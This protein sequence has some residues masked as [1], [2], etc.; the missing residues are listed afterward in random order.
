MFDRIATRLSVVLAVVALGLLSLGVVAIGGRI[1]RDHVLDN[2]RNA[3]AERL[4]VGVD[5]LRLLLDDD[6]KR[7]AS[8]L[9]QDPA[10]EKEAISAGLA[11]NIDRMLREDRS[12]TAPVH[13][14]VYD[15]QLNLIVQLSDP[16]PQL[17]QHLAAACDHLRAHAGKVQRGETPWQVSFSGFCATDAGLYYAVVVPLQHVPLQYAQIT[18][19]LRKVSGLVEKNISLPV[20]LVDPKGLAIYESKLWPLDENYDDRLVVAL[21]LD[22]GGG[23]SAFLQV[24]KDESALYSRLEQ[25]RY[26]VFLAAGAI[27][28]LF[29]LIAIAFLER[30]VIGPLHGLI[31]QLRAMSGDESKL[32]DR[33]RAEGNAE[34]IQLAES[35]NGMTERLERLYEQVGHMAFTDS[36]TQLPNRSFFLKR[37]EQTVHH[38]RQENKLFGLFIIDLDRFRDVNDTIGHHVG[39][40]L[41][42]QVAV[43]LRDK[44]RESDTIARIGG[45]EFAVLLPNVTAKQA[46]MAARMLIQSLRS[47]I[48]VQTHRLDVAASIGIAL[49]PDHGVDARTLIQRAEVAMYAAKQG[50]CGQMPYDAGMD[51]YHSQQLALMG[52]LRHAVERE[53]FVLYYQPKIGLRHNRV[54]G[55]EALVRWRH[56][57]GTLIMPETFIPLL[58]Q[59]S[60]MRGL[61]GWVTHEA[62]RMGR[63]LRERGFALPVAVNISARDL[64]NSGLAEE[65]AE[66]LAVHRASPNWLELEI[67]ESAVMADVVGAQAVL[68]QLAEMGFQM[69]IDDFGTGY[70]SLGYLKRL[71]VQGVKIDKSFVMG[72][73]KDDNDAAIVYTSIDLTHNLGLHVVAEGVDD[74][75]VL[76]RLRVHGCDAAQGMYLSRPLSGNELVDWLGKSKWGM[77]VKAVC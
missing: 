8:R 4:R 61:T 77:P 58:E 17:S 12:G 21:P 70:S 36:L 7:T 18:F 40:L 49:Y 62:L 14:G 69:S 46:D 66:Y 50:G 73:A 75:G 35:F 60:L 59:S 9:S 64:Q 54:I 27:T 16:D 28:L 24:A 37:L 39:D 26:A 43:R 13:I 33:I 53:Q 31:V 51:R 47:D 74:E 15:T 5:F 45:D 52:E 34:S 57:N 44:L 63:D 71:P 42:Q 38:A 76:N 25:T 22:T 1:Y 6:A 30:T 23:K 2:E 10:T 55:V 56:P 11:K 68:N 29:V 67:T 48:V 65:L 72:M 20:R 3:L 19:D 41:L 32:G